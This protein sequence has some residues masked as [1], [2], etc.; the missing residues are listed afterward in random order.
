MFE[1]AHPTAGLLQSHYYCQHQRNVPETTCPI[2]SDDSLESANPVRTGIKQHG[3]A[4]YRRHLGLSHRQLSPTGYGRQSGI[5]HSTNT[6][7]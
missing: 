5:I 7:G 3:L 2:H 6:C 4:T 1:I